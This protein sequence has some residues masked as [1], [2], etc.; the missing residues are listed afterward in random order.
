M[1]SIKITEFPKKVTV[2]QLVESRYKD[3]RRP[4]SWD[5]RVAGVDV[6]KLEDGTTVR[7][8]SDGG[9]SP[10]QPSW[11]IMISGGDEQQGYHWTLYGLPRAS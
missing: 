10:P 9:Q 2:S 1:N 4:L 8:Y 7:L 6:V 3:N 5:N 11:S